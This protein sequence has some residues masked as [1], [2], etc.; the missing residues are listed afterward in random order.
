MDYFFSRKIRKTEKFSWLEGGRSRRW[1]SHEA[2]PVSGDLDFSVRACA[3][4]LS[5]RTFC[6]PPPSHQ[7]CE[8]FEF[9]YGFPELLV[10]LF[11]RHVKIFQPSTKFLIISLFHALIS[12]LHTFSRRSI[13]H[14]FQHL[15][16]TSPT[17]IMKLPS[18]SASSHCANTC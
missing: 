13:L 15:F 17:V 5:S 14:V 18:P 7:F 10:V 9:P 2:T 3:R 12:S 1:T 16:F 4:S 8:S 11:L 6:L